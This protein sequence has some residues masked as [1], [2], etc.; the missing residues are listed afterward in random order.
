M[1]QVVEHAQGLERYDNN[2]EDGHSVEQDAGSSRMGLAPDS[3]DV[4]PVRAQESGI[5]AQ[6]SPAGSCH[7]ESVPPPH[8][9]VRALEE[10]SG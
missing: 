2:H 4:L 1:P 5:D 3:G 9:V 7:G 8:R 10:D 6:G